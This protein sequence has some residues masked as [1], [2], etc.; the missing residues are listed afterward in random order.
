M[1]EGKRQG[2][3]EETLLNGKDVTRRTVQGTTAAA[4]A[5]SSPMS[6]AK[7]GTEMLYTHS[8]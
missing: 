2:E 1:R 5:A 7:P 3:A 8:W 4:A 6:V